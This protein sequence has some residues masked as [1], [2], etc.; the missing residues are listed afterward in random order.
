MSGF[1]LRE[2]S[3]VQSLPTASLETLFQT[4]HSYFKQDFS[5]L[6]LLRLFNLEGNASSRFS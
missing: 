5:F 1:I 6:L 2:D 3:S 4:L